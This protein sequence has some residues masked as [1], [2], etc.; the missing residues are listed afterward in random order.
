[1]RDICKIIKECRVSSKHSQERLAELVGVHRV[2]VAKWELL[3]RQPS[4]PVVRKLC[5][6]YPLLK[7]ELWG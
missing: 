5:K 7:K 4:V 1:M 2:T 3:G 6:I